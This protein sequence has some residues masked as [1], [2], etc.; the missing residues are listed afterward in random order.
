[1]ASKKNDKKDVTDMEIPDIEIPTG[2][3][4]EFGKVRI[5]IPD[6]TLGKERNTNGPLGAF[7]ALFPG[8]QYDRD[9]G[10]YKETWDRAGNL[11]ISNR[12]K[13]LHLSP[14]S[15]IH[16]MQ[17]L[18]EG[19]NLDFLKYQAERQK[20]DIKEDIERKKKLLG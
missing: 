13:Q 5:E 11:F 15:V 14:L 3:V 19:D 20:A 7:F 2:E 10:D 17:F 12:G 8:S 6:L 16:L 18:Q 4:D 1:M 9:K